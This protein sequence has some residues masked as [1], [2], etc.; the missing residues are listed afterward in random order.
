MGIENASQL[1]HVKAV[2]ISVQIQGNKQKRE[3][4]VATNVSI[5]YLYSIS[6]E[7]D[8]S[9]SRAIAST[10]S[11]ARIRWVACVSCGVAFRCDYGPNQGMLGL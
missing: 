8:N 6:T 1:N 10:E 7:C 5:S 4:S 2:A 9:S 3:H 11:C